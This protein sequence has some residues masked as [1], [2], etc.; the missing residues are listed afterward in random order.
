M[1]LFGSVQCRATCLGLDR[2]QENLGRV[3]FRSLGQRFHQ[4]Y[5]NL[6]EQK[7]NLEASC[8]LRPKGATFCLAMIAHA[9]AYLAFWVTKLQICL[10]GSSLIPFTVAYSTFYGIKFLII[11]SL[12]RIF[13][14]VTMIWGKK[15]DQFHHLRKID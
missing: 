2:W 11:K 8:I 10:N 14:V 15:E 4:N 6:L 7:L 5:N 3:F 13:N 1:S 12:T 9:M